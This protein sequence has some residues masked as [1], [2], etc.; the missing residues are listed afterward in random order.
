[1]PDSRDD[2]L[3]NRFDRLGLRRFRG[4]DAVLAVLIAA[5]LLV[6]FEGASVRHAGE[7]MG[8]GLGRDFVLAVGRPAGWIAD[9]L[10]LASVSRDATSWL[11]PDRKL[12]SAGGGF[13][14][15][16]TAVAG[17]QVPLV[18]PDAFDPAAIGA[19][20]APKRRLRTL[21]VTGDSM[22][23][24]LDAD[25]A[26]QLVPKGVHVIQDPHI[27]TGIS[28]TFIADW[29]RLSTGQVARDHPDA[30]VMFLGANDGFPM[31]GPDGR[32]VQ[33]CGTD[34]AAIYANRA[35]QMADT[36]RQ[37]GAARVY[38]LTLPTPRGSARQAIARV[39]NAAIAVAAQPWADQVRVIDT[40]PIFTPGGVYRDAMKI[41]GAQTLVRQSDGI[42]LND[43]GSKLLASTVLAELARENTY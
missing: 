38:W 37:N 2:S 35:R 18:T 21:L 25:L 15:A 5:L 4:R 43:A 9:R 13:A 33:C 39:V 17:T 28:N 16:R 29:G 20:P 23:M 34:W 42:H 19:P 14:S 24:P 8:P 36:Y 30:V 27:G 12:G 7:T 40:V 6:L 41:G 26:Q 22:V 11:S 10:P 31:R 3:M 32:Q 1:L